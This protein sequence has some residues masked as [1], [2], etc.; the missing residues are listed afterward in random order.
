MGADPQREDPEIIDYD[1]IE[2]AIL[3]FRIAIVLFLAG[4]IAWKHL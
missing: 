2:G 3:V 1:L 4:L